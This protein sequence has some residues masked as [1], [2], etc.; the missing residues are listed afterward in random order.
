MSMM[1]MSKAFGLKVGNARKKLVLLKLADNANDKGEC[2]PSYQH[3][4]EQCEISRRS[5]MRYI[6]ELVEDGLIKK[7]SRTGPKGNATNV[8]VVTLDGRRDGDTMTPPGDTV[9]PPPGDRVTP[10]SDTMTPPGDTVTPPPGDRVSPGTS[11]SFE[12]VKEPVNEPD[13]SGRKRP[14]ASGSDPDAATRPDAAIQS[15]RFWGT[16]V[17]LELAEWMWDSLAEQLG[18]DKPRKPNLARWANTIRLMR[19]KDSRDPRHI[20]ALYAWCRQHPFWSANVQSPDKLREKWSQLAAQRNR[21]RETAAGIGL[22]AKV[23]RERALELRNQQ[24]VK[25]FLNGGVA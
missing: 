3:I 15:G 18:D 2:W 21:E 9:S 17:D 1:L 24:A 10:P 14:D 12:P 8:Y 13:M 22:G 11:H 23:S 6:D 4:A 19:E 5:A 16:A 25:E 20:R 7:I